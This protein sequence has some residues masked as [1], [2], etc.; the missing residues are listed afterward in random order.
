MF[1]PR[2]SETPCNQGASIDDNALQASSR[3]RH[4]EAYKVQFT[5]PIIHY[6]FT[7]N[8]EALYEGIDNYRLPRNGATSS[9]DVREPLQKPA[10]VIVV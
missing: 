10:A 5:Y 9:A 7:I 8:V 3:K 6:F 1:R 2:S 4:E